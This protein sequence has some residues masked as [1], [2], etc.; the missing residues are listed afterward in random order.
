MPFKCTI[1][2]LSTASTKYTFF[3]R[4]KKPKT[5]TC[6]NGKRFSDKMKSTQKKLKHKSKNI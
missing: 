1:H 5:I 2:I 6:L 4:K 3:E